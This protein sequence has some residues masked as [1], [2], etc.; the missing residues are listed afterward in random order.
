MDE[1]SI[2][3]RFKHGVTGD[4]KE[5]FRTDIMRE[6]PFPEIKDE[7]FCP[8]MLVWN[9][10]GYKYKLRFFNQI[11]YTVEYQDDGITSGIVKARMNSP[12]ASMMAYAELNSYDIPFLSKVKAAINYW[13]FRFCSNTNNKPKLNWWYHWVMPMGY[14]MHLKDIKN[15]K[16]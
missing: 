14:L 12:I 6:Y 2:A 11:I 7:K 9:R 8:E 1:S 5:V 3:I 4:M 10:I 13:R 16:G 15:V